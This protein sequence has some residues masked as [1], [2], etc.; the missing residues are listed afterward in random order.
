MMLLDPRLYLAIVLALAVGY[1]GGCQQ[2][3]AKHKAAAAIQIAQAQKDADDRLAAANER[4]RETNRLA[5]QAM[6]VRDA[7]H[8]K[9][10]QD[11]KNSIDSL[12]ARLRAG[13]L[14]LSVPV[15]ATCGTQSGGN[16][17]IAGGIGT[18]TRAELVPEAAVALVNI[19]ADGDAAVRQLNAVIDAYGDAR[20]ACALKLMTPG[21]TAK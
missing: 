5:S 12:N 18:E 4:V 6:A 11:A 2:N 17:A 8:H 15:H 13:S 7:A 1:L 20:K 19:A 10:Q 14:S 16:P 3:D 9:E 21:S